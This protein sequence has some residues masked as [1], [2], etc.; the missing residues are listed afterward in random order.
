MDGKGNRITTIVGNRCCGLT[1]CRANS[2]FASG[3]CP[4]TPLTATE[5]SSI[6][7]AAAASLNIPDMTIAVV[8]RPG[9][10]LGIW[11]KPSADV[12]D[13]DLAASLA[14]TGAFFS[15]EQAPS[16]SRTVR[17]I[18]GIHFPPG[19]A[20]TPNAALY[21]IELTNRG[22]DLNVTFDSGKSVPRAKAVVGGPCQATNP[23]K[24]GGGLGITTGKGADIVGQVP[25]NLF[26][27][28]STRVN[29]FALPPNKTSTMKKLLLATVLAGVLALTQG[30]DRAVFGA[31]EE[32]AITPATV[33]PRGQ[34]IGF[35]RCAQ[36]HAQEE[37]KPG[38]SRVVDELGLTDYV[39]LSEFVIWRAKDK[40]AEA[41]KKG[42]QSDLGRRILT[43][44]ELSID[45]KQCV[46]CHTTIR[47]GGIAPLRER[48]LG[49]TCE[50]CHGPGSGW[51]DA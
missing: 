32:A 25:A 44:L 18:S 29:P 1:L 45:D 31:E 11:R 39:S 46:S 51:K 26:D 21:G 40:H 20:F 33:Q 47:N 15:N 41:Y 14:R 36:C 49:V 8:D 3:S 28:D 22:C 7:Q 35:E 17:F 23:D 10:I 48:V 5:V 37:V 13:A 50:G 16:S 42:L 4:E 19:V 34:Y 43:T 2:L 6:L 38:Q 27:T 24:S 12:R 9:N 30:A